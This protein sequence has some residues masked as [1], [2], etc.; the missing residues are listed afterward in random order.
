M[1]MEGKDSGPLEPVDT[2]DVV[3]AYLDVLALGEPFLFGLWQ[4]SGVSLTQLR[5][6]RLLEQSQHTA[7]SLANAA[8]LPKSSLSR[9]LIRLEDKNLVR[10][11]TDRTDRRRVHIILTDAGTG[12]LGSWPRSVLEE[13]ARAVDTMPADERQT[14]VESVARFT[15]R[16]RHVQEE[17]AHAVP[18][19]RDP[20][21]RPTTIPLSP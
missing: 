3:R 11:E 13:L 19:R 2:R 9:V 5:I 1:A 4:K 21:T 15:E 8:G 20:P 18:P 10:R 17:P 14:F 12:A 7:G 6:L 16:M